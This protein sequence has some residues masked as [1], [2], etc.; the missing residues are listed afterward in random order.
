MD[1]V[2]I[3]NDRRYEIL[4]KNIKLYNAGEQL[5]NLVDKKKWY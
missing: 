4:K 5:H 3:V 2:E 1:A